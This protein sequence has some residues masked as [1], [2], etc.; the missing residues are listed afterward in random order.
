MLNSRGVFSNGGGFGVRPDTSGD[1][2]AE[3]Y[4]YANQMKLEDMNRQKEMMVFANR[5]RAQDDQRAAHEAALQRNERS[6]FGPVNK[7]RIIQQ[8]PLT[9]MQQKFRQEEIADKSNKYKMGQIMA[10]EGGRLNTALAVGKQRGENEMA[11]LAAEINARASEGAASRT[12]AE[13]IADTKLKAETAEKKTERDFDAEQKRLDRANKDRPVF[14]TKDAAGN[15]VTVE[16]GPDGKLR[17]VQLD[18]EDVTLARPG[19]QKFT[20]PS[21]DDIASTRTVVQ[22]TLNELSKLIDDKNE[23]TDVGKWATGAS[24]HLGKLPFSSS[25]SVGSGQASIRKIQARNIL[26]IIGRLKN[27]S[28]TGATGF[29]Q[30][31]LKELGVLENAASKLGDPTLPEEDIRQELINIRTQLRLMMQDEPREVSNGSQTGRTTNRRL[32]P[33]ELRKKYEQ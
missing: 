21:Q 31:N 16:R 30:M 26:D 32:S 14:T 3:A 17:R 24:G 11:A 4:D 7:Q 19:I 33:A 22:D 29:G 28:R 5:L 6:V 10:E 8:A 18:G 23:L 20:Q 12:S 9:S 13:K 27:Q 25:T 15:E 2:L 1:P